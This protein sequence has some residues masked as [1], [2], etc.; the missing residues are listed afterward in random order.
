[1]NLF[2]EITRQSL[3]INYS[4]NDS[5][6]THPELRVATK[7][8]RR[9]ENFA[10]DMVFYGHTYAFAVKGPDNTDED[11]DISEPDI[12]E[13]RYI[14]EGKDLNPLKLRQVWGIPDLEDLTGHLT[15]EKTVVQPPTHN[16]DSWIKEQYRNSRGFEIGTFNSSLL[17][18]I[19]KSQ[20]EKWVSI[21]HDYISDV[22]T[23][24]HL[25]ISKALEVVYP[26]G[27][28]R[29]KLMSKLMDELLARYK[30]AMDKVDF[31][32]HEERF[33]TP[34]TQ[35]HYFNSNLQIRYV[36]RF[37]GIGQ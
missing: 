25:F 2:Q 30:E 15:E 24:T 8:V 10:E 33:G 12:E 32:L 27:Y 7:I 13:S 17:A 4:A 22:I 20:S 29:R 28:V 5:F 14:I 36:F 23:M 16:I 19:M 35:S 37:R 34:M 9:N 18:T 31:I 11:D 26:N 1:M 21:A 6:G 3:G